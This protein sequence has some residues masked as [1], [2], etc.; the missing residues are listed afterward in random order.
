MYLSWDMYYRKDIN[1]C[2]IHSCLSVPSGYIYIY[3]YTYTYI[4]ICIYIYIYIYIYI[5]YKY[6]GVSIGIHIYI[7]IHGCIHI[8][9]TTVRG[10]ARIYQLP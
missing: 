3:I 7:Y 1:I 9:Y 6:M 10:C 8:F 5:T 2:C 4:Y